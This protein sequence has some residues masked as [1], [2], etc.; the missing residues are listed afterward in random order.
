MSSDELRALSKEQACKI[1]PPLPP[2]NP[3]RADDRQDTEE[4]GL[5]EQ[6]RLLQKFRLGAGKFEQ[7]LGI[8]FFNGTAEEAVDYITRVRGY[9]VVPAAPALARIDRD[10]EYARGLLESDLA[11]ADSGFMVLL[12]RVLRGR[13]VIRTSG[14][15]YLKLLLADTALHREGRTFLV[16]PTHSAREK[17]LAWLRGQGVEI[18]EADTYIAPIY[19]ND[20]IDP[21]LVEMLKR[22]RPNH[23][24]IA[25]GGGTQEKLGY[26]LREHLTYRPAIHCIGA[27]LAFLTGDQPPIPT[28]ADKLYLGWLLRLLRQ[29]HLYGPRYLSAFRLPV[30]IWKHG[31]EPPQRP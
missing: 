20:V 25:V 3:G 19:G 23:I 21:N 24:V 22:H 16:L 29:P 12:W 9:T 17:A 4:N 1:A 11:I 8:G 6:Q 15:K 28:W 26:Y 31:S 5:V 14:L 7:I 30:L 27:A 13:K 2:T 18:T 10:P